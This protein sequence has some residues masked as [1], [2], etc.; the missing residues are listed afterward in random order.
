M[1]HLEE[2]WKNVLA[3]VEQKISKP[4]FETWLKSTKLLS[5]KGSNVTIAAPNSFARDWLENHYVHLIAGILSELTGED[6]LIKFV[7]QKDQDDDSLDLPAPVIQAKNDD[8]HAEI[9]PGMLNPK[10]TFDTFVIGSGNRFAHAASLA[11]AEAPAKAYN[12]FFIYGGVGL[13]KTHLMH[14]IG[15][16]VLEHNPNAKVVYLSSE[17]FTNEFINSIRDNKA[18][19][20]RNKYRNVDVLLIDDIQF[21]AGKESTQEEFFHTFNTL[22]TESKQ[23]VI[24]SDRPPKEIPTLEDRLRS[25]FE[26]GLITDITPPDLETRIAIL[27]KK[28]KA[29]GLNIPNE[30]MH[31]IANQID[32]NIR[33]LE[34]ALIRVVAYSSLVNQ[35]ISSD[36][37]A[38]ALKDIIPNSKPRMITILDIQ[39]AVG[40]HFNIRLEDFTAK[41]RTKS[42]AF[43]RQVAMYLSR[44]L[45]D[46][47]LPK[48]GEEFGGRDHTTVIHAHEKIVKLLKEDQLLQQDIKQI[49]SVLGK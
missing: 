18:V 8:E 46:F 38:A 27:R 17:K 6:L 41:R 5:Y 42:I 40:E 25:R 15:H 4:S 3:Q 33:E 23:I 11:V 16:Y 14:A 9:S 34:G 35:D 22:H 20:F 29:D 1:E 48:I 32:T 47:S 7:V 19:D 24:S 44:E 37:A 36:L 26:W 12:P 45:T 39:T 30:V 49:R 10:Y 2:L 13:G 28:A 43:P 31:Y 21:L